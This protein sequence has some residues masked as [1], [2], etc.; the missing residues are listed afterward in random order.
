MSPAAPVTF[1]PRK[2]LPEARRMKPTLKHRLA[3]WP[4]IFGTVYAVNPQGEVRYF[5]YDWP[6]AKRWAGIDKRKRQD[7]RVYRADRYTAP[8]HSPMGM[9]DDLPRV[10]SQCLFMLREVT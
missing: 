3:M 5:D 8:D 9:W 7:L 1:G 10:G 6:A 4:G 2:L